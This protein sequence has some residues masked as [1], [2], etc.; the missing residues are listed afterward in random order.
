M[1]IGPQYQILPAERTHQHDQARLGQMEICQQRVYDAK[2]ITG[3]DK[4][5]RIALTSFDALFT[6]SFASSSGGMFQRA[7][8]GRAYSHD[9]PSVGLCLIACA[10]SAEISYHSR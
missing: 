5:I 9:A 10:A 3:I 4:Y 6:R 7:N 1:A 2:A 8:R